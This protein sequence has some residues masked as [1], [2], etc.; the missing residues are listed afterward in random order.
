MIIPVHGPSGQSPSVE[1]ML[2]DRGYDADW[3]REALEEKGIKP[4]IPGR[5]WSKISPK[6]DQIRQAEIQKTQAPLSR[7]LLASLLFD[8][9][10]KA[11][12]LTIYCKFRTMFERNP[13]SRSQNQQNKME[14]NLR[15]WIR[16]HPE[17]ISH[18]GPDTL[19]RKG[20]LYFRH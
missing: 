20:I 3:F 9:M 7:Y 16:T 5:S 15:L 6:T 18:S 11:E 1:W 10:G 19:R 8:H 17:K 13:L 14:R 12:K 4:C 2:A